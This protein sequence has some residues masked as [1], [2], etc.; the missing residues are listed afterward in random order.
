MQEELNTVV[1]MT[2]AERKDAEV[3]D[4][5]KNARGQQLWSFMGKLRKNVGNGVS[6]NGKYLKLCVARTHE[7]NKDRFG[8]WEHAKVEINHMP[9]PSGKFKSESL[10]P[11]MGYPCEFVVGKD[12]NQLIIINPKLNLAYI[13][14]LTPNVS[15]AT[16]KTIF[17]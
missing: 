17:R 1:E 2:E 13:R 12:T 14:D 8:N 3:V 6:N 15:F 11:V 10:L 16:A 7:L 4:M 5:I 9:E